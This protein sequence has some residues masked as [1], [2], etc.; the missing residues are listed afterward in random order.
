[1]LAGRTRSFEHRRDWIIEVEGQLAELFA[2]EIEFRAEMQNHFHVVLRPRSDIASRWTRE[3]IVIR[4]L[5]IAKLKRGSSIKGWEPSKAQ[6][7]Q[8][9]RDN[10]RVKKLKKR[11]SNISWFM[12][13]LCEN[14]ARRANKEDGCTGRFFQGRFECRLIDSVESLLQCGIYVDLNMIR[15]G[16]AETPEQSRYTSVHDRMQACL[17]RASATGP[18]VEDVLNSQP[19]RWMSPLELEEGPDVPPERHLQSRTG[20]RASDKGVLPMDLATYVQLLEWTGRQLRSDKRGAIP[21]NLAP[22]FERLGP[23][24]L[25]DQRVGE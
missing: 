1:M 24:N 22:I 3:Q 25:T 15:A 5:K 16:E 19:D 6:V 13:A 23:E 9:L 20:C 2:I 4:W 11:L 7:E 8:N 12:G 17:D 21:A 10:K 14:I 18:L